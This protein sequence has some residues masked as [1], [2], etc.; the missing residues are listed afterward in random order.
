[1]AAVEADIEVFFPVFVFA[2]LAE[3]RNGFA[4]V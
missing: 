3:N 1:L 2:F 4:K